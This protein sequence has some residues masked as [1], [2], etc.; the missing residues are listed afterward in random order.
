MEK[1]L[2]IRLQETLD[3][4]VIL[5][6]EFNELLEKEKKQLTSRELESVTALLHDKEKLTALLTTHQQ[7][8]LGFC[9]SVGIDPSYGS[10][11]SYLYRSGIEQAEHI[12]QDWTKLKNALIKSQALN[13]TNE[14]ILTELMRRNKIKQTLINNIGRNGNTYG[15]NSVAQVGQPLG[16]V[17]QV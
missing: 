7:S 16:W 4:S 1:Q 12:L 9:Q 10:L 8:I 14:A 17:E 2:L 13:K 3:A 6:Q 11:R 15:R 5:A